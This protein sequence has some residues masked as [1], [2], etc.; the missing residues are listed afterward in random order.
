MRSHYTIIKNLIL[1]ALKKVNDGRRHDRR[2]RLPACQCCRERH[3]VDRTAP[4]FSFLADGVFSN[5]SLRGVPTVSPSPGVAQRPLL[6]GFCSKAS[7]QRLRLRSSSSPS[8]AVHQRR[9]QPV[10]KFLNE[11]AARCFELPNRDTGA[12][13]DRTHKRL[14]QNGFHWNRSAASTCLLALRG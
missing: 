6:Q 12:L 3:D 1:R 7:A 11:G 8:G 14:I 9:V 13:R 5:L 2:C 4:A 10:P